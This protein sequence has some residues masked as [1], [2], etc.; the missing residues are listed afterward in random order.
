MAGCRTHGEESV[1]AVIKAATKNNGLHLLDLRG[2]PLGPDVSV[3]ISHTCEFT[4]PPS[5]P[6]GWAPVVDLGGV[7]LDPDM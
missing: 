6:A 5:L 2:V 3:W 4:R 7:P 1:I